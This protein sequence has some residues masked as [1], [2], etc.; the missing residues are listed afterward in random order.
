VSKRSNKPGQCEPKDS[1][2]K[3]HCA[4]TENDLRSLSHLSSVVQSCNDSWTT[5]QV[6]S[7]A[8]P[9]RHVQTEAVS[10]DAYGCG[11]SQAAMTLGSPN[12]SSKLVSPAWCSYWP[13]QDGIGLFE[14][15]LW[16]ASL[17]SCKFEDITRHCFRFLAPINILSAYLQHVVD[18]LSST[19]I[20]NVKAGA[21]GLS[22]PNYSGLF[23]DCRLGLLDTTSKLS[24]SQP[25]I[26]QLAW[27]LETLLSQ[28]VHL[29]TETTL[30]WP[31]SPL[32][33]FS[34]PSR[35]LSS[36]LHCRQSP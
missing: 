4:L 5:T 3:D 19:L 36:S 22:S 24:Q 11:G 14:D 30:R 16:R 6:I 7:V 26:V 25:S 18:C 32:F 21:E 28:M 12:S 33:L 35:P 17:T 27:L 2:E 31:F 9:L 15:T 8:V 20:G 23:L 29:D 1:Q 13:K 10:M 34:T